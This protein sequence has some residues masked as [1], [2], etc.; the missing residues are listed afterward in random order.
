MVGV[1]LRLLAL[2]ACTAALAAAAA[3]PPAGLADPVAPAPAVKAPAAC[4]R[5]PHK[6]PRIRHVIVI[7][8]ENKSRS[9]II[10]HAPFITAL[11]H[12]CGQARNYW[13]ITHP[14]LP[15]YLAMTSGSTHGLQD[16]CEP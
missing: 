9:S 3:T 11:A 1:V 6:R 4:G 2:A 10:G 8:M 15:N 14:S 16:N 5:T 7:V 12:R 13:A